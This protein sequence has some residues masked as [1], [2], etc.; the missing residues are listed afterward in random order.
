MADAGQQAVLGLEEKGSLRP[1]R[2]KAAYALLFWL[3][4]LPQR[5]LSAH[6]MAIPVRSTAEE[7]K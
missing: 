7:E 4:E 6:L 3:G 1:E 2:E 5:Y